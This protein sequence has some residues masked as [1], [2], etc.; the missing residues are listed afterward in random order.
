MRQEADRP[1]SPARVKQ[2]EIHS[3]LTETPKMRAARWLREEAG[4]CPDHVFLVLEVWRLPG[5]HMHRNVPWRSKMSA[6]KGGSA[7]RPLQQNPSWQRDVCAHKGGSWDKPNMGCEPGK[8]KWLAKGNLEE[9]P[10]KGNSSC[11]KGAPQQL[12]LSPPTCLSTP[13]VLFFS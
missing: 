7:H 12:S 3:L 13:T 8:S 1:P 10:H 4:P 5:P 11:H 9:M 2:L 6:V